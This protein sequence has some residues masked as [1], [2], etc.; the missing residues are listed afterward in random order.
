MKTHSGRC[1]AV[2]GG[3][4]TQGNNVIQWNYHDAVHE[5]W[6]ILPA[7][8]PLATY[9]GQAQNQG[10]Q[11]QGFGGQQ[12]GQGFGGQ[13]GGQGFGQGSQQG[14]Q[15]FSWN[16]FKI[17]ADII[18]G[19]NNQGFNQGSNLGGG[20]IKPNVNYAIVSALNQNKCIDVSGNPMYAGNLIVYHWTGA[21]N[22]KYTFEFFQGKYRIKSVAS[23]KYVRVTN[24][25]EQDMMWLRVDPLGTQSDLWEL[26]PADKHKGKEGYYHL[27]SVFGKVIDIPKSN[28]ADETIL[29]QCGFNGGDNQTWV[30]KE[31]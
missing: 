16:N 15:G 3:K 20:F 7:D 31:V 30:L 27:K 19:G 28:L 4:P 10:Q 9:Q 23:G 22:Q 13:Q 11:N 14:G 21:P 26:V 25:A 12:G 5:H 29:I 24:D 6:I 17:N 2:N 8:Q 18:T 1:L